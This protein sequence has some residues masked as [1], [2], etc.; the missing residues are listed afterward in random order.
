MVTPRASMPILCS[1]T[2]IES[3]ANQGLVQRETHDMRVS[4]PLTLLML[5]CYMC[6]QK[7]SITFIREVSPSNW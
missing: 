4:P 5:F 6:R 7:P 1:G 3:M 2:E